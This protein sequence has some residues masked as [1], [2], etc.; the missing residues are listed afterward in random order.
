MAEMKRQLYSILLLSSVVFQ[1]QAQYC[2]PNNATTLSAPLITEANALNQ[3]Q[4]NR[5]VYSAGDLQLMKDALSKCNAT[6]DMDL[7]RIEAQL[8]EASL[9]YQDIERLKDIAKIE[10]QIAALEKSRAQAQVTLS[11]NLE[12]IRHSGLFIVLLQ[13]IDL[14]ADKNDLVKQA[15]YALTPQAVQSLNGTQI[16]RLSTVSELKEVKDIITA[17]TSGEMTVADVLNDKPLYKT[18]LFLYAAKVN[19]RPLKT[20]QLS[21]NGLSNGAIARIIEVQTNPNWPDELRMFGVAEDIINDLNAKVSAK[22]GTI[23]TENTQADLNQQRIVERSAQEITKIDQDLNTW[24]TRINTAKEKAKAILNSLGLYYNDKDI[25]ANVS[26]ALAEQLKVITRLHEEWKAIKNREY[27]W[28]STSIEINGNPLSA[29]AVE[30]M[31]LVKLLNGTYGLVN[32]STEL[33]RVENLVTTDYQANFKAAMYRTV[34]RIWLFPVG[35]DDGTF[36]LTL[37]ARFKLNEGANTNNIYTDCNSLSASVCAYDKAACQLAAGQLKIQV[38]GGTVP[39]AIDWTAS[40]TSNALDQ[41]PTQTISTTTGAITLSGA[42]AGTTYTFTVTDAMTCRTTTSLSLPALPNH[43]V[44]VPK[45]FTVNSEPPANLLRVTKSAGVERLIEFSVYSRWGQLVY[46][47]ENVAPNA[48]SYGWDGTYKGQL[49]ES[50]SFFYTIKAKLYNGEETT[51][52][53]NVY[54]LR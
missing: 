33:T 29:M 14:Y 12:S 30:A 5:P 38:K 6:T 26:R 9:T 45:A 10:E 44:E 47:V 20:P 46:K 42:D 17:F 36:E 48:T 21:G 18:K 22:L 35:H 11:S 3:L 41:T 2:D 34:E 8:S 40:P 27:V 13:G 28:R 32:K 53:G 31:R 39:Y 19:V 37:V 15:Q 25:I 54:L 7:L 50:G 23:N 4:V 43:Y 51:Y 52:Q 16:S 49:M 24:R 1:I